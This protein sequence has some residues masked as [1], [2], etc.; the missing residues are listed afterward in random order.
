MGMGMGMMMGGLP[1]IPVPVPV[2]VPVPAPLKPTGFYVRQSS[3]ELEIVSC[4]S[5]TV[6]VRGAQAA[7]LTAGAFLI[8]NVK[9]SN[10]ICSTC[11]PLFRI[12]VSA[13]T[14]PSGTTILATKFA[15]VGAILG[16]LAG[17]A[18][19]DDPLEPMA[20]CSHSSP[21]KLTTPQ[22]FR[23]ES[24]MDIARLGECK[25]NWLV[26]GNDGR[27]TFTNCFVGKTG[28][29]TKCF[30]CPMNQCDN[31]CGPASVPLLN[32]DG[33][34]PSFDFGPACCNH[35][36]C[37]SSLRK[38]EFCDV[39]FGKEMLATCG[40]LAKLDLVAFKLPL[41][42]L[43]P[44]AACEITALAFYLGVSAPS[45]AQGAYDAA[46]TKQ[47]TYDESAACAAPCPAA[48]NSGK[49]GTTTITVDLFKT[50]GD[51]IVDYDMF[52]APDQLYIDYEGT[53]IFDTGGLVSGKGT[54]SVTFS[55]STT[56][57][58]SRS[59]PQTTAQFG[60]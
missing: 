10:G 11:S 28:D 47:G 54:K 44:F 16:P 55:G 46:Q 56:L 15:T 58:W 2:P 1:P 48:Q 6:E 18:I 26:K 50:S 29:P 30:D 25:D 32:S 22:S 36:Y 17:S 35:D 38:K 9:A 19:A 43:E 24:T 14:S 12:V 60:A 59:M 13:T 42:L 4:T 53:R 8:Y 51:F 49:S 23:D 27:C 45:L 31:G 57:I 20:A 39:N 40:P 41:S 3:T 37:W 34:F 52:S 7:K 21:R 5:N 33:T